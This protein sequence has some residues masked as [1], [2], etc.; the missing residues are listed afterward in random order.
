[1]QHFKK[2]LVGVD[3]SHGD[4][5]CNEKLN[6]PTIQ[7]V[8]HAIWLAQ[9]RSAE[10]TFMAV[11]ELSPQTEELLNKDEDRQGDV[12]DVAQS[13]LDRLV[14][15]AEEAGVRANSKF[16]IGKDWLELTKEVVSNQHDLLVVGTRH[17]NRASRIL[18]GS[19]A[20]KLIRRCPCPVWV[21]KPELYKD[22]YRIMVA[23]DFSDVSQYALELAVNGGQLVDSRLYLYHVI[24]MKGRWLWNKKL[25]EQE[26]DEAKAK[27][28]QKLREQLSNTDYRTL[29]YGVQIEILVGK[30]EE[31]IPQ[32]IQENQIDLMVMGTLGRFGIPGV[33]IGNTAERLLPEITCSLLAIKPEGF[34]SPIKTPG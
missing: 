18:F 1:M 19:A 15:Q 21:T 34:E 14:V 2:I 22:E 9:H 31:L 4:R 3:L 23:S 16:V 27:A 11:L 7:A 17:A 12:L 10:V 5:F 32:A 8:Q 26:R 28:E 33:L 29:T 25:S 6:P 30:P 20:M 24:E 13:V